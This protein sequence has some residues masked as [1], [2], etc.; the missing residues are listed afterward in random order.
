MKISGALE[1]L[2]RQTVGWNEKIFSAERE[3]A[4]RA[5]PR[6]RPR[7]VQ[8]RRKCVMIVNRAARKYFDGAT[9]T[10]K[11]FG[12]RIPSWLPWKASICIRVWGA[13]FTLEIQSDT[14]FASYNELWIMN[15][16]GEGSSAYYLVT[17]IRAASGESHRVQLP[18]LLHCLLLKS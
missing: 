7:A 9:K 3:H 4:K 16:P 14:S 1:R 18:F 13:C 2:R 11:Y 15:R 12:E 5:R 8:T 17:M 6:P 10:F